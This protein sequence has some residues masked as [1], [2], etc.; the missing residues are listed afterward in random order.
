MGID[1]DFMWIIIGAV[2]D[3]FA[4]TSVVISFALWLRFGQFKKTIELQKIKYV[5]DHDKILEDLQAVY[6][7]IFIDNIKDDDAISQLRQQIYSINRSFEKLLKKEDLKCVRN[8]MKIVDK[9]S[10][11]MNFPALRKNLDFI[12]ITFKERVYDYE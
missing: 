11:K 2:S 1:W 7:S 8:L 5:T 3:V 6:N 10:D 4:I 9:E 12:I